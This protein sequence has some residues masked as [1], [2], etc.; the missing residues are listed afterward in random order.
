MPGCTM[1]MAVARLL[2]SLTGMY[3]VT[4]SKA[5]FCAFGSRVVRMV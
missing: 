4:V 5:P 1:V 3:E 2:S